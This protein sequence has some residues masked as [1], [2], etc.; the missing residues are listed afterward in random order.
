[1]LANIYDRKGLFDNAQEHYKK[2]I[3]YNN[4]NPDIINNYANFLCQRGKYTQA[5]KNYK[6]VIANPQYKTPAS[7]NEN[8]GVC[9]SKAGKTEQAEVFFRSAL[10]LNIK[11]PNS[12]YYLMKINLER[13][14]F[15]KARAFLQRLENLVQPSAEML[16]AGYK[17]E[18]GLN[19]KDLANKY[20]S[21]LKTKFPASE[22][23]RTIK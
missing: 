3:K 18:K 12:L 16:L 7:A 10:A 22:L 13:K 21:D 8:A 11:M 17:I 4:G 2:S 19:N 9:S 15:M 23:L 14:N 5:I 20:M 6:K 1:M